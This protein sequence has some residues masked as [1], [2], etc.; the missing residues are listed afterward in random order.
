MGVWGRYPINYSLSPCVMH[1]GNHER[2]P[3]AKR[4]GQLWALDD[5]DV[6]KWRQSG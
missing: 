5:A 3:K 2:V 6:V 1:N 4:V